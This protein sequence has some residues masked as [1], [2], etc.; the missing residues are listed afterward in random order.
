MTQRLGDAGA[1][2]VIRAHNA[3]VRQA[4]RARGGHEIKHTGDGIM[5]SFL[6]ATR[7]VECAIA[8][9]RAVAARAEEDERLEVK[10]ALNAGE[11][12]AE[13]GDLYGSSVQLA[14]RV[15][16]AAGPGQILVTE[17]VRGLTT[18]KG[19]LVSDTGEHALKGFEEPV[20]LYEV[21]WE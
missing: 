19:F 16:D 20:R 7:A 8:I 9:Q 2:E 5:G 13:E 17:V 1:Q 4:M 10:V 14:A 18:G 6:S 3:I 21:R 12:V 15:R 11:P